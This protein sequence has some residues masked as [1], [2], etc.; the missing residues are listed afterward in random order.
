MPINSIGNSGTGVQDSSGSTRLGKDEFLKLL[1]TQ[2]AH[3]DPLS[4]M[5]SQAFVAQ[6]AQFANVEQLQGMNT[7]METMVMGQAAAN[8]VGTANLVG[9]QLSYR[10]DTVQAAGG[11]VSL[12]GNLE[13]SATDVTA[14]IKDEN[15]RTVRTL[16]LGA[17]NAGE[18]SA[19]WDGLDDSG[20]PVPPGAYK[21]SFTATDAGGNSL[22]VD[23]RGRGLVTGVTFE[24]GYPELKVNGTSLKMS[25]VIAI[26]LAS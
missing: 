7:R 11:P 10:T 19:P 20:Q 16:K 26:E 3:Q 4:P 1:M 23:S 2:L 8:Q 25:D 12:M 22:T 6:L 14:V 21:V 18:F 5:D 9:R 24:H 17:Q 15:G 13:K